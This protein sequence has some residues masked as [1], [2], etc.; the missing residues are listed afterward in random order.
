MSQSSPSARRSKKC[1]YVVLHREANRRRFSSTM[2]TR[3]VAVR[4]A[5]RVGSKRSMSEGPKMHRAR[6]SWATLEN[7]RPKDPHPHVSPFEMD[8]ES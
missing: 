8:E 3:S 2:L 1:M 6:D 4:I 7:A 5:S